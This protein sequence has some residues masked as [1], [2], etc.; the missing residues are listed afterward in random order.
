MAWIGDVSAVLDF[1]AKKGA[2]QVGDGN[3][4]IGGERVV[5]G[6]GGWEIVVPDATVYY[7]RGKSKKLAKGM[8]KTHSGTPVTLY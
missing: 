5:V 7:V 4:R 1:L 3:F 8:S 6:M 2:D